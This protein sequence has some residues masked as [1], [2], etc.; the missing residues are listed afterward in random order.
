MKKIPL[1][2]PFIPPKKIISKHFDNVLNSNKISYG[3]YVYK[4]ENLFS[5]FVKNKYCISYNSGSSAL[6]AVLKILDI[7]YGDE[8]ITC[9]LTAEPTS[10]SILM[11]GAK[12][13]WADIMENNV[14]V[15]P[16]SIKKK[17]TKKTKA[18]IV[19][20]YS[21]LVADMKT[22]RRIC[23]ENKIHLI[24]DC[25]HAL[26]SKYD[27]KLL[28][29]SNNL[30]IFSF[31][32]IKHITTLDGGMICCHNKRLY[33]RLINF[34][35]FGLSRSK[36]REKN[37]IKENGFKFELN[38][39][40][41][42]LGYV[43]MKYAKK[44]VNEYINNGKFFLSNIQDKENFKLCRPLQN[45]SPSFWMMSAF[46]KDKLKLVKILKNAGIASGSV[47][48]RNDSHYI[49]KKSK[50]NLPVLDQYYNSLIHF[51]SGWW[52]SKKDK[53]LITEILN[54]Y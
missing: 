43:Q 40:N 52:L 25:A 22:I 44:I 54:S 9:P 15:D 28:G 49:F 29:S 17:I 39:Y 1:F 4:F 24:E 42:A 2:K 14:V 27:E 20:H 18:V 47:H 50:T 5:K 21:G 16:Y 31:Q 26:G 10:L 35:W 3:N 33:E 38:N 46:A 34:R 23:N 12:V 7:G 8:V 32:A 51:P 41:S 48:K 11:S 30:S 53:F 36:T 45:T 6:L 37:N 19:V 13:V